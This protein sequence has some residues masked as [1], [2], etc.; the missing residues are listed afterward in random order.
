MPIAEAQVTTDRASRY[1]VQ[2]CR[3]LDQMSRMRHRVP[4]R[5]GGQAPPA[6][7]HAEWSD[8]TGTIRFAQGTC[9]LRAGDDALTLRVEADDEDT[10]RQLRQSIARRLDTIGRRDHLTVHWRQS[11]AAD[12]PPPQDA[13]IATTAPAHPGGTRRAGG[14]LTVGTIAVLAILVH[15][16]VL[17]A[18]L[19]ASAWASWGTTIVLAVVAVKIGIVALHGV[20]GRAAF[21]HRGTVGR[22]TRGHRG[23]ASD[24]DTPTAARRA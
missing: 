5:H 12:G 24:A 14:L 3:H 21:R 16:G 2:L 7:E 1:L 8:T 15:V 19:A 20:L 9:T 13:S 4:T 10:L 18:T 11:T 6:V 17:G 22:W 23:V